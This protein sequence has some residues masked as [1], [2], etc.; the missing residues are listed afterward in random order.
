ME[1]KMAPEPKVEDVHRVDP[2]LR[3]GL[4]L[5]PDIELT[6]EILPDLR[7]ASFGR[8]EKIAIA[9]LS[10]HR[11]SLPV[12]S[13]SIDL[14]VCRPESAEVL[15]GI[16]CLH[17]GGFVS[18]SAMQMAAQRAGW[19]LAL[20]AVLVFVDYR[21]A[22]EHPFP[23]PLEDCYAALRWMCSEGR[24]FGIDRTR[25]ALWGISAGGGLAAGLAILARD[26]GEF[27]VACQHLWSPMLDD[28]TT[29]AADPHAYVGQF[30]WNRKNNRFGWHCYLGQEPGTPGVS[31][32]AAPSR[33]RAME[34][35]P[36]TYLAVGALDLFL[37]ENVEYAR[38]LLRGGV[39]VELHVHPGVYHGA[40]SISEADVIKRWERDS[41]NALNR[42]LRGYL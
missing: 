6:C 22:P 21:L 4:A 38:R 2:Q 7:R 18:G 8:D 41:R 28:R 10:E 9:G 3:A 23:Q 27:Q 25:I 35:L 34:G 40:A 1:L 5:F 13:G 16:C 17:G 32:Y 11:V 19:A 14:F 31:H 26:R 20:N 42:G 15:P 30:V 24:E 33:L 36:P 37:E 29:T 39:P 12:A